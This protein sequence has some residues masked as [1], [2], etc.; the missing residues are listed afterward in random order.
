[1]INF[2]KVCAIFVACCLLI[3]AI[4]FSYKI[5]HKIGYRKGYEAALNEPHQIDT[6]WRTDTLVIDNPTEIVR[7]RDRLIYVPVTEKDT[8]SIHDTT[9]IALQFEKVEY[10]DSTYRAIVSGFQP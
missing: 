8:I 2:Q 10:S 4:G 6:L 5:G 1:M 3:L 9:Y 7:W